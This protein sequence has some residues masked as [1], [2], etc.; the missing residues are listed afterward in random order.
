MRVS[1][2]DTCFKSYFNQSTD[3]TLK[4]KHVTIKV[5]SLLCGLI[6]SLL[7]VRRTFLLRFQGT[8]LILTS[9]IRLLFFATSTT[10]SC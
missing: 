4:L 9:R 8:L 2:Q 6:V 1:P 7:V 10:T 5:R 3:L